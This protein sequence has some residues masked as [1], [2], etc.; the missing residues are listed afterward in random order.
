MVRAAAVSRQRLGK[1]VPVATD[2]NAE[3][4]ERVFLCGPCREVITRILEA[5]SSVEFYT[6]GCEYGTWASETKVYALV[7]AVARE[8]LV[9]TQQSGKGLAGSVVIC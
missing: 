6:G 8:R 1:H 3:I 5:K 2:T 4:G 9:K 7:E